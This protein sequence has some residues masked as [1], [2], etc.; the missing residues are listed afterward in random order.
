MVKS[1]NKTEDMV[2]II[3]HIQ[4]YTPV[5]SEGKVAPIFFGGDQLTRERAYHAQEA[6]AQSGTVLGRLQGVIPK[7]EDWHTLVTFYQV[8]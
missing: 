5:S 7:V 6:K 3:Q 4:Q 8:Y 2:D 1:E